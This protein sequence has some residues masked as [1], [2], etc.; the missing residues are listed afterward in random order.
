[1]TAGQGWAALYH[2]ISTT[3]TAP[4]IPVV[5]DLRVDS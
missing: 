5:T 3:V 4:S 2:S 1:M